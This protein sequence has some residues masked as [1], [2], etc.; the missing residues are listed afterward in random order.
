MVNFLENMRINFVGRICTIL[1]NPV[2]FQFADAVQHSQFFTG[3]VE[4]IDEHGIWLRHVHT[5]TIAF[6]S[7]P[8][9]GIVE[10]QVI[11][12]TDPRAAQVKAEL[13]KKEREKKAKEAAAKRQQQPAFRQPP[14]Q[15]QG[16]FIPIES[17]TKMVR[18]NK[19]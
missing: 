9:V 7:F 11:S 19:G 5:N 12:E 13:E 17:L 6:Y 14:P 10:E 1:T 16:Q 15:Q 4:E 18:E 8:V 2:S 3:K